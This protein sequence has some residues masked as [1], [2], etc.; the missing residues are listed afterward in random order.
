METEEKA[1]EATEATTDAAQSD[2]TGAADQTAGAE[3][4][5][6]KMLENPEFKAAFERERD[7]S[8]ENARKKWEAKP[9]KPAPEKA[10]A[11]D[12]FLERFSKMEA[13]IN[14]QTIESAAKLA[15]VKAE[16]LPLI[17]EMGDIEKAIDV[18][19]KAGMSIGSDVNP[20][21]IPEVKREIELTPAQ[22]HLAAALGISDAKTYFGK[23]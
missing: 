2:A 6:E 7:R 22:K 15:G 10:A 21:A 14:R 19:K 1:T 5:F 20:R 8:V 17:R 3:M 9:A 23:D 12:D 11:K 13:I 16:F 4:S 18:Q